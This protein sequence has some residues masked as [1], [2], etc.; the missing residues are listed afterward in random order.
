MEGLRK[1]VNAARVRRFFYSAWTQEL[2]YTFIKVTGQW[3]W[4]IQDQ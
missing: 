3:G 1:L 2:L 4:R